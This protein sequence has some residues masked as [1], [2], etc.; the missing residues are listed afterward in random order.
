M[1]AAFKEWAVVGV[2]PDKANKTK[3]SELARKARSITLEEPGE[4]SPHA[5]Q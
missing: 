4:Y 3:I 1:R 5:S 2:A